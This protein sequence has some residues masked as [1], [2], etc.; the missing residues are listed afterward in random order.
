MAMAKDTRR[1]ASKEKYFEAIATSLTNKVLGNQ[2]MLFK[3]KYKNFNQSAQLSQLIE[4]C[5]NIM[6][7]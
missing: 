1:T 2:L 5:H 7:Q 6:E 4:I 3:E